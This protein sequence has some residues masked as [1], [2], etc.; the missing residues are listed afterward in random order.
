[1]ASEP[2]DRQP[3]K[4]P[5]KINNQTNKNLFT[6]EDQVKLNTAWMVEL[7]NPQ[8]DGTTEQIYG[9]ASAYQTDNARYQAKLSTLGQCRHTEDAVW[10]K[11]QRDASVKTL[12][13]AD[14]E[15]D[16]YINAA[17]FIN[18]GYTYLPDGEP[19]KAEALAV[20]QIFLDYNFRV[21]DAY[22]AEAD[23][24][25]QMGQNFQPY[26][27][28]LTQIGA[29]Q[30]YQKAAA[31][32]QQVRQALGERAFTMGQAVNGEMKAARRATDVAIADLYKTIE[33]M[34]E[35]M[36]SAELTTLITQLKGI[37]L[38]ARQYI[39]KD[40]S[41]QN[42]TGQQ[43]GT[44]PDPSQGGGNNSGGGTSP[45]PSQGGGDN[46]GGGTSPDPSQGGG[47]NTGGD[48]DDNGGYNND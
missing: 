29:W 44:S 24:I 6:M 15:Q 5:P 21:T 46:T 8:H 48:P 19:Q 39:I 11:A 23:K 37:E 40:G 2:A 43:G 7:P 36:P 31:S 33:A 41:N 17:R 27:S 45:D 22:G 9:F 38:Y 18:K 28:Y 16:G 34:N 35:L 25:I 10:L 3:L 42:G 26:V 1:V 13:N 20:E 14:N 32:A 30:W 12:E 47:D 4:P